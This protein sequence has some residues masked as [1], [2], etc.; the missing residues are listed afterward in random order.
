MNEEYQIICCPKCGQ[1][2]RVPSNQGVLNV[3]CPSCGERFS[4][5]KESSISSES[6]ASSTNGEIHTSPQNGSAFIKEVA[7]YF[8]DFLET[9]FHKRRNPKRSIKLRNQDNLLVGLNLNKYPDFNNLLWKSVNSGF[10]SSRS[11]EKGHYKTTIPQNLLDLIKFQTEKLSDNQINQITKN[12]S[13]ELE[14]AAVLYKEEY[15]KAL[16]TS[17]EF[18]EKIIKESLVLPFINNIEKSLENLNLGDE[19]SIYL[20]EEELTNV[21]VTLL[22]SKISELLKFLIAKQ[23][24]ALL[25]ELK[26]VFDID[27]VKND[28][29]AFFKNFE[30]T[31]LFAE[32]YEIDRNRNILD[33]QEFY[34]YFYDISFNKIRYPVFYLPFSLEKTNESL[35]I[36]FDSQVYINKKALGYIVQEYNKEKGKRGNLNTTTERIIYLAEHKNDFATVVSNIVNEITNFFELDS[37]INIHVPDPQ[38]AKSFLVRMSNSCYISLFDKSDEAL[39]N[40]YEEILQ[41]L[42]NE[43][44]VLAQAFDKLIDDFIHKNPQ[45]FN[46]EVE[47]EW[48]DTA[49]GDRLVFASPI[50]LNGE[51]RQILLA[52]SRKDCKYITVEGP[53]GTGKSH[54]IT[55]IAFEAI[56][57]NQ[58]VLI[59]SDKKEALD[60][61]EVKITE[62]MNKVRTDKKFQNPILRLGK[63]GNTYNQ[64]LSKSSLENIKIFYRAVKKD[65]QSLEQN[66]G[67][68]VKSLKEDLDA[69]IWA[70]NEID[71]EEVRELFGLEYHYEQN[72]CHVDVEEILKQPDSAIELEE[73]RRIFLDIKSKCV[74]DRN[75]NIAKLSELFGI[76]ADSF[77]NPSKLLNLA[78]LLIAISGDATEIT[79]VF[80]EKSELLRNFHK[81]SDGDLEKLERLIEAY[82]TL[83]NPVWG[84]FLKGGKLERINKEFKDTFPYSKFD[85]SY[86][87][88]GQFNNVLE[89]LSFVAKL[90]QNRL[91]PSG[92]DFDYLNIVHRFIQDETMGS[93]S[94]EMAHLAEDIEYLI[95]NFNKYPNTLNKIGLVQTSLASFGNNQFTEMPD[96][97][98][99]MIIRY[100]NLKQK[101]TKDFNNIP[102]LN[103]ADQSRDIENLTTLKMT[104][105]L[106]G[107]VIDFYEQNRNDA[108]TIRNVIRQK[109]KFNRD[110]FL[111]LKEAFPC[112]LAGVR[113]YAEYIPLEPGLFDL[114]IIDEASQVSIAQAF[115]ALLRAKKVVILGD[116]K[117]FSNVKAAHARSDTNKEYL[118][119]L[120]ATFKKHIS[121]ESSKLVKL[122]KFNIKTSILEFFEF[123]NNY[124]TQLLKHFRGYKELI[125]YSNKY[126]Y[127]N[128]FH[129][130]KIRGKPINE[131]LKFSF[132][133]HDGRA[134]LIPNTNIPEIKFICSKL[135]ALKENN[136]D[137]S[138]GIITP[139][140]NQQKMLMEMINKSVDRDYYFENLKLK[141]MTF[142]TCQGEERDIIFYSM[143]ATK[144]LDRLWGVFIKDLASVDI[145]EDGRIKA[146]RLNVG[147]S[148]A[149]ECMHFVL[150]QPLDQ[151]SGSVG[152]ALR[153]YNNVLIE[154]QQEKTAADV[155]SNSPMESQVLN[156]FY[157]TEFWKENKDNIE[158]TPQFKIGKYLKQLD[159][160]YKH[161]NYIVDFLLFYQD[162]SNEEHKII[163]EY[164]GFRE[165]FKDVDVIN[166]FNYKD[167]YSDDDIYR[168]KVL[169]GYGY[170]FLRINRFN[171]GKDPIKTLDRR[172]RQLIGGG[173]KGNNLLDN[174]LGTVDRLQNGHMKDCP[175]CKKLKNLDDF[176]DSSLITGYGRFCR[177]CKGL[178]GFKESKASTTVKDIDT[179]IK[180][181]PKC[182]SPMVLRNGR[183]GPFFG[184]SKYPYCRGTRN[185]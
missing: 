163:I 101:I 134:E 33:K 153:H 158:F 10:G 29:N 81:L 6:F 137:L 3:K 98:F 55:A 35:R 57:K 141:I 9:D 23:K 182:G 114:V 56:L 168:K 130:M 102:L 143:V 121:N 47:N 94:A 37:S 132:V 96:R 129:V 181:C 46:P 124:N 17:L 93:L 76:H 126:F 104:Y 39:V 8:M 16:T 169:E 157:Q 43:D 177:S 58:C 109:R 69:E 51:Q 36:Y 140:T 83:R 71:V 15:D 88:I 65:Y 161:P 95:A 178:V 30:V 42:S 147:F 118:N 120:E 44:G 133:D 40:D 2:L 28:I 184:C 48:D 31:D 173:H 106:D 54:T 119:S 175:K 84:Y 89:I 154:A 99:D 21:L 135:K 82:K 19:N 100:I 165:H 53:P 107:R 38:V 152:E 138:V 78:K 128:N 145:E 149:K 167:Y 67:K 18:T 74:N 77:E 70:C 160:T 64:I 86:K 25:R 24:T 172:I 179:K 174:I 131:V 91:S 41:L 61:V 87:S 11:I 50:P 146:Q 117:Q 90:K 144:E 103:Y 110:D 14:K 73:F 72:G 111:R 139:H 12:I 68:S 112:I 125:S 156:W 45:P 164:D 142:D 108:N 49:T 5:D 62:T 13:E 4:F 116:K 166:E 185:C 7:K 123:I 27:D 176:R 159:K 32:I 162:G 115:P 113:D 85:Y 22:E 59:L 92:V 80:E 34:F 66:I 136:S 183:Y 97:D 151:Y 60:V 79:N 150:S 180:S 148:R 105:L 170:K 127:Q 122:E 171:T 20:M 1:K 63:T 52:T 75:S 155:D 26:S